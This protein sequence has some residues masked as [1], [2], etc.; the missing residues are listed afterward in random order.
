MEIRLITQKDLKVCAQLLERA[1][2]EEPYNETFIKGAA[3]KYVQDKFNKGKDHSFVLIVD[4]SLVGFVLASLSY[5]A[6]GPQAMMEEIVV[7]EKIRGKGYAKQLNDHL[8]NHFKQLGAKTA[9]LWVKKG[10]AAHK[11]HLKNGYNEAGDLVIMFK[12]I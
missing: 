8:E 3:L 10:T 1:Y 9:M 11:L 6:D 4:N 2:S 7:D 5:W 12:Q